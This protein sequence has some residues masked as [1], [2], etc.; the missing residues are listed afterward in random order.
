MVLRARYYCARF[1]RFLQFPKRNV[2]DPITEPNPISEEGAAPLGSVLVETC[3]RDFGAAIAASI[4]SVVKSGGTSRPVELFERLALFVG[5]HH[6]VG[7]KLGESLD[8]T[9]DIHIM[10]AILLQKLFAGPN[11]LGMPHDA[12]V[13]YFC[14]HVLGKLICPSSVATAC[15]TFKSVVDMLDNNPSTQDQMA[16]TIKSSNPKTKR[17]RDEEEAQLKK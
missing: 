16:K 5:A 12:S 11:L 14:E 7:R 13:Q 6:F 1:D 3:T 4:Q 10:N 9:I 2:S 17:Q 15:C 8:P